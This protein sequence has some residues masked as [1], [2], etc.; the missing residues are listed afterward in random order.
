LYGIINSS[1]RKYV[2]ETYGDN[3]WA[4]VLDV[5]DVNPDVFVEMRPHS[6]EDTLAILGA[7][8]EV[9]GDLLNE[10]LESFG[11][12]WIRRI[13]THDFRGLIDTHGSSFS[14]LIT[15]LNSM[16][17]KISST[18]LNYQP[19]KFRMKHIE[20]QNYQVLYESHRLGLT[21]F[22]VGIL[23]ELSDFFGE[24]MTINSVDTTSD[25]AGEKS[26]I[27]IELLPPATSD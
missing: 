15:N 25:K 7:A 19:P 17:K 27:D 5:S 8:V 11:R 22:V 6:D 23:R 18:F 10:H 24:P 20:G 3:T 13:A 26:C 4:E 2:K 21:P 16:H 9:T 1:F 12:F 14:Q